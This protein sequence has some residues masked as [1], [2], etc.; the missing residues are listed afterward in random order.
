VVLMAHTEAWKPAELAALPLDGFEMY[1][2]HANLFANAGAALELLLLNSEHPEELPA[3]DLILLPIIT[4]DPKYLD[5]WAFILSQGHKRVTTMGTDCHRNT[6]DV[7]L[8][9]GERVDSY[10]RMM[11]W[12]SNHLL[13]RPEADG[14]WDDRQLKDALRGGRLY[15]A[16]E[17]LGYPVG[18]DFFA[19]DGGSTFEMGETIGAAELVVR[20]P[21]I[22]G[23]DPERPA[24][25][26]RLRILRA[27][28]EGWQEVAAG[29]D[30]ELR[31]TPSAPGAYRAEVRMIPRHL[32]ADLGKFAPDV[33]SRELPWIYA[34]PIYRQ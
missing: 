14:S 11:I 17:V 34:N 7:A 5:T 16:M 22:R 6:F 33:G 2:L 4:E 24:P 30:E 31:F 8:A 12:F 13:V 1:N 29:S 32:S 10:R 25:A 23:L 19:E 3:P 9:D 18:F 15:G 27:T 20:R 21:S 26:I 28:A